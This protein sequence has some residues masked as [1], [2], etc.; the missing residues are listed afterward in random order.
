MILLVATRVRKALQDPKEQ[1]AHRGLQGR[2]VQRVLR[3]QQALKVTKV[4]K[5]PQ[6]PK[7][8]L[9]PKVRKV[10]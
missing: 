10:T 8:R 6:E 4:P 2:R 5:V 1:Q 7:A 9:G 3:E